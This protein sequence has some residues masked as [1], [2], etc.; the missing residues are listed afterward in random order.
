MAVKEGPLSAR[1]KPSQKGHASRQ[2]VNHEDIGVESIQLLAP[3]SDRDDE[4]YLTKNRE[5]DVEAIQKSGRKEI[6]SA[7]SDIKDP[8]AHQAVNSLALTD[9]IDGMVLTVS[10]FLEAMIGIA[11]GSENCDFVSLLL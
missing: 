8:C 10:G 7:N 11:V 9:Q 4:V 1:V 2:L 6:V 3:D 5:E